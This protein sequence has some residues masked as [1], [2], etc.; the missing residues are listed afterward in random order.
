[1]RVVNGSPFHI[2][3]QNVISNVDHEFLPPD[4]KENKAV[5]TLTIPPFTKV[6][7]TIIEDENMVRRNTLYFSDFIADA[8]QNSAAHTGHL[9]EKTSP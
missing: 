2:D 7:P 6:R 5:V 9:F 8:V 1:M 4:N 3:I